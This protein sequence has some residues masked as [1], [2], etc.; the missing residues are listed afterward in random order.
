MIPDFF[1]FNVDL[2]F[3]NF[4]VIL[5]MSN[6]LMADDF[7]VWTFLFHVM[8]FTEDDNGKPLPPDPAEVTKLARFLRFTPGFNKVIL[9]EF[10][11]MRLSSAGYHHFFHA[12][13]SCHNVLILAFH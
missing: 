1:I 13:A 7:D 6:T 10:L 3:E 12:D 11:G 4:G 9:G 8:N 2:I 5:T